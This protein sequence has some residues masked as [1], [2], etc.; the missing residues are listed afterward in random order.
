[1]TTEVQ[2][3][4]DGVLPRSHTSIQ[5][6]HKDSYQFKLSLKIQDIRCVDMLRQVE[7]RIA[8]LAKILSYHVWTCL[9]NHW[10]PVFQICITSFSKVGVIA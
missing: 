2:E 1:M 8:A 9:T 5:G 7:K 10:L 3:S 4:Y 6:H